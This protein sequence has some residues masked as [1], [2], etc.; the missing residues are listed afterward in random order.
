MYYYYALATLGIRSWWKQYLTALQIIQFV[1]DI[2]F[3]YMASYIFFFVPSYF[4]SGSSLAAWFGSGLLT[5]YLWLFVDFFRRTYSGDKKSS[6]N[7]NR[8]ATPSKRKSNK[9]E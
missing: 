7:T 8:K 2:I 3:C 6:A 1:I 4:C 5:S 9:D